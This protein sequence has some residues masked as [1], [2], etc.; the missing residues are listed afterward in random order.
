MIYNDGN[1]FNIETI[2]DLYMAVELFEKVPKSKMK[3]FSDAIILKCRIYGVALNVSKDSNLFKYIKN[4]GICIE[5]KKSKSFDGMVDISNV[6]VSNLYTYN[7]KIYEILDKYFKDKGILDADTYGINEYADNRVLEFLNTN[8]LTDDKLY[9]IYDIRQ[10]E[11]LFDIIN[12]ICTMISHVSYNRYSISRIESLINTLKMA[13]SIYPRELCFFTKRHLLTTVRRIEGANSEGFLDPK[14]EVIYKIIRDFMYS[15]DTIRFDQRFKLEQVLAQSFDY[16]YLE[17]KLLLIKD[18]IEEYA[19][20]DNFIFNDHM[21]TSPRN[22]QL[23]L[24]YIGEDLFIKLCKREGLQ[25][26]LDRIDKFK[27]DE[28][29]NKDN[30]EYSILNPH[31]NILIYKFSIKS[32][33]FLDYNY[34]VCK[35]KDSNYIFIDSSTMNDAQPTK[36]RAIKVDVKKIDEFENK[37]IDSICSDRTCTLYKQST[38]PNKKIA[39]KLNPS[40]NKK[41]VT[42]SIDIDSVI[43]KFK[44]MK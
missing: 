32:G 12:S 23:N 24:E 19:R 6:E 1:S 25:Y 11:I 21:Q 22:A 27:L 20:M 5:D 16:K 38:I 7:M 2:N 34:F 9:T 33:L 28:F 35:D 36:V 31:T 15:L 3:L 39:D 30:V 26:K 14:G 40:R 29:L 13:I 41:I 43:A 10:L 17:D 4:A 18:E 44:K 37:F 42:E 8:L